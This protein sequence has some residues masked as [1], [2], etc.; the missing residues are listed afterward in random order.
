[1]SK[2]ILFDI[3]ITLVIIIVAIIVFIIV[4]VIVVNKFVSTIVPFSIY[5]NDRRFTEQH[6]HA[7]TE[8][9]VIKASWAPLGIL[10]KG[11]KFKKKSTFEFCVDT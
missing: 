6:L 5:P 7:I 1:M 8:I 10:I 11:I 2:G 9:K 3:A 4:V